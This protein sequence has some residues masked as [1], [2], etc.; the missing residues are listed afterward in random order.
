MATTFK[1]KSHVT[2]ETI[3]GIK[4][5]QSRELLTYLFNKYGHNE[6]DQGHLMTELNLHQTDGTVLSEGSVRPISGTYEFYR[7]NQKS[8]WVNAGLVEITRSSK[9]LDAKQEV[10]ALKDRIAYL[11]QI[12]DDNDIE[13]DLEEIETSEE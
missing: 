2:L 8:G 10:Q 11:E 4:T 12:L 1:I 3:K 5:Q 7:K 13:Y 9:A 6:V